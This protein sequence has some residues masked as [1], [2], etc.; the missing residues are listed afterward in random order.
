LASVADDM[1]NGSSIVFA[2]VIETWPVSNFS[3]G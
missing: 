1:P 2:A 3:N